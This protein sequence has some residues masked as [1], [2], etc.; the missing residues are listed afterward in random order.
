MSILIFK[1]IQRGDKTIQRGDKKIKGNMSNKNNIKNTA[2]VGLIGL[3]TGLAIG[4]LTAPK[5]GK[6]TR[7]DLKAKADEMKTQADKKAA[8]VKKQGEKVYEDTR[9]QVETAVKEGKKTVDDYRGR[10]ERALDSA[11]AELKDEKKK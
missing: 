10:A 3:G 1:T 9:K 2:I 8:E 11:K 4:Y 5:S 7:A 6:E